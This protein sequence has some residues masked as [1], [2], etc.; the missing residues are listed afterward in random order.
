MSKSRNWCFTLNADESRGEHRTWLC[1]GIPCPVGSW[2]DT[3]K[4]EYLVCQ[5]ERVAHVHIQG[6][7]QLRNNSPLSALKKI[8]AAAHWEVR[9]GTHAQA[10]D[11]S[12]KEESRVNGPWE[13][14]NEKDS[15][16]KRNDLEAIGALVK[17]KKTN[18]EILEEVGA[19]AS[20]F[21]KHIQWLRFTTT[22]AES[23]RQLQGVKVITLYGPTGTGKTYAAVN[24]IA[25]NKDY[26]ICE[27]PSHSTSKVWFDGYEGQTC[28]IL[29]DFAGSFCSFRFILRLLDKYKLKVEVKGG[30]AW[31]V[32][33][34]VVITS[35]SHPAEWYKDVDLSPLRRRLT[36]AGS[37]IRF[38]DSQGYYQVVDWAEK[39]VGDLEKYK[40]PAPATPA[41][42]PPASPAPAASTTPVPQKEKQRER[43][44]PP[45]QPW[46]GQVDPA[47]QPPTEPLSPS[48]NPSSPCDPDVI[49]LMDE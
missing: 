43:E 36:E 12:K 15:Q 23:D 20:K 26:Y 3:G 41:S 30:H 33:T 39:P 25:G 11:Y 2:M 22:E 18:N 10:K 31:A 27:A 46:P 4:I 32:W 45:T 34:T 38:A 17:A 1:P 5:V 24:Y 29:D 42:V 8:N 48:Q 37:E 49:I 7:I 28:L 40:A 35:N 13:L 44:M 16:G 14:G 47:S 21:A 6:Y 19:G 9:R